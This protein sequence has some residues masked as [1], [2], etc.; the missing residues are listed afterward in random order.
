MRY[1]HHAF[2]A[3]LLK[4][5]RS[6]ITVLT[7]LGV[8]LLPLAGG[9]FMII[10]KDPE[11]ARNAGL[12]STKARILAG[13]ADWPAYFAILLQGAAAAGAVI[14]ALITAWVFGSEF[15]NRTNSQLLA[16]PAPRAA[17]VMAKFALLAV[18]TMALGLL[19]YLEGLGVGFLVRIPGWSV[20]LAGT[21]LRS[22]LIIMFLTFMLMPLVALLA[23]AGR[24]YL[25]PMGWAFF[26]LAVGQIAA[27]LG[28][29]DWV[30]WSVPA[31][32]SGAGGPRAA[33]VGVHGY[34]V[35]LVAFLAG[36]AA[37]T[38]WWQRADQSA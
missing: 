6:L 37:T 35:V 15:S 34:V 9:L 26:T 33:A 17:I 16:L 14:F 1:F 2:W 22:L 18:W 25:A 7:G 3:E 20:N 28:W 13:S 38:L 4:A 5:R 23:S 12:I 32:L 21:S 27:V 36:L 11:A 24:G 8:A 19:I 10:L 29:G 30:P 31:L